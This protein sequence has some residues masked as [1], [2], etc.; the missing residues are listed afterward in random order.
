[1]MADGLLEEVEGLQ[2]KGY[3]RALPAMSGL[4]YRQIMAYLDGESSLAAS[5]ERIK[6]ETHRFARQQF[7]WFRP[8]DDKIN[9][10]DTQELG[11]Q[12]RATQDV[13]RFLS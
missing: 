10:Y 7:N 12:A 13:G 2:A 9:W 1:M 4:G 6:Y 5:V 11:W 3:S 8:D